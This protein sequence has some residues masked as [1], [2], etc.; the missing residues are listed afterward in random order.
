[1]NCDT[2]SADGRTK[3]SDCDTKSANCDTK[4]ADGRTKRSDCDTKSADGR[5]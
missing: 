2:K 5:T 3:R 1:M 4:S